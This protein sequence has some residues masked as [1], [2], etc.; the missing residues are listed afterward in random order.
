MNPPEALI[1]FKALVREMKVLLTVFEHFVDRVEPLL[2]SI[3]ANDRL[4]EERNQDIRAR[5]QSG[6]STRELM[7]EF[8][9]SKSSIALIT[10]NGR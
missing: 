5:R 4:I 10:R 8:K 7:L 6:A 1:E 2:A 3:A 9:L